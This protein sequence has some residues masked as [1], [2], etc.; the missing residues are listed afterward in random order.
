MA[1][2]YTVYLYPYTLTASSHSDLYTGD[3]FPHAVLH[4]PSIPGRFLMQLPLEMAESKSGSFSFTITPDNPLYSDMR[5]NMDWE[6]VIFRGS[7]FVWAGY[8]V[9]RETDLYRWT[10]YTCEGV[11]GYLNQVYL[12]SFL[13]T[14]V[15]PSVLIDDVV[16]RKYNT[17]VQT[18]GTA[19]TTAAAAQRSKHRMFARG[20]I[21]GF[22]KSNS[23][24]VRYTEKTLS[25]MEILQTRLVSYFGG[26]LYV[27]MVSD[28][29][30]SGVLWELHYKPSDP[31]NT[32]PYL[33]AVGKNITEISY[34]Y[35][36]TSF[37]TALVPATSDGSVLV[38]ASNEEQSLK[39]GDGNITALRRKNSVI[40]RNVALVK[41]YGL[42]VGLYDKL[43]NDYVDSAE[44][45]GNT[46]I[47]AKDLQPPKVTFEGSAKDTTALTGDAPLQIAQYVPFQDSTRMLSC[48]MR[49][50]KLTL[51][52]DDLTQNTLE[53]SGYVDANNPWR[54]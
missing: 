38:T 9:Q 28:P 51:Q 40:F 26:N 54:F 19:E 53:L 22:D 49:I 25:A 45:V 11:L 3:V 33:V 42:N 18:A 23:R 5:Q 41:A 7:R 31:E 32:N 2:N 47:A 20:S 44:V 24:I 14:N 8:P 52:L 4:D 17:E 1:D 46:L 48:Q 15:K 27:D 21:D 12:P 6:V 10:T 13:Y 35:D 39:D 16:F 43:E 50:T 30:K 36:T 29:E 37:Y 34:N